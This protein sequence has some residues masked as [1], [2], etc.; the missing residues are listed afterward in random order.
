MSGTSFQA[1]TQTVVSEN[2]YKIEFAI[3]RLVVQDVQLRPR[4]TTHQHTRHHAENMYFRGHDVGTARF[5]STDTS[6]S[7]NED[8]R[9][10]ALDIVN[11]QEHQFNL[12]N[13]GDGYFRGDRLLNVV[14]RGAGQKTWSNLSLHNLNRQANYTWWVSR[15]AVKASS[16]RG[17][18]PDGLRMPA[19]ILL[20]ATVTMPLAGSLIHGIF[21][22]LGWTGFFGIAGLILGSFFGGLWLGRVLVDYAMDWWHSPIDRTIAAIHRAGREVAKAP[23]QPHYPPT[24]SSRVGYGR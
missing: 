20:A 3:W 23:P 2:G 4:V 24:A 10:L 11:G 19:I 9:L 21:G 16:G 7:V 1:A 13:V 22:M 8:T 12:E 15:E 18:L 17:I 14:W 5:T 6:V